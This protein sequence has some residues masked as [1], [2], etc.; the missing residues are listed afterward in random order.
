MMPVFKSFLVQSCRYPHLTSY[1]HLITLPELSYGS[2]GGRGHVCPF[3][4]GGH[5]VFSNEFKAFAIHMINTTFS[6]THED[7][8]SYT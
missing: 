5:S 3:L 2:T 1:T 8:T 6:F 4:P 7:I